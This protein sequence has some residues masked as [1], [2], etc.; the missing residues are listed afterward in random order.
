MLDVR[1]MSAV[2]CRYNDL[3][4]F[5][6]SMRLSLVKNFSYGFSIP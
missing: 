2:N 5:N 4:G 6:F 3:L 1:K